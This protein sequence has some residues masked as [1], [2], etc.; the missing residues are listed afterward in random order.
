MSSIATGT[1][2]TAR[3]LCGAATF[4]VA[5][6]PTHLRAFCDCR[7]RYRELEGPDD[8][9]KVLVQAVEHPSRVHIDIETDDIEAERP[10]W[11]TS[12]RENIVVGS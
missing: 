12:D 9:V 11:A 5:S 4:A 8:E 1:R 3:A 6:T 2:G 10:A 7:R